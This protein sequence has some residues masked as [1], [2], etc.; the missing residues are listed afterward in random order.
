MTTKSL[1]GEKKV[2]SFNRICSGLFFEH[3]QY[4][5]K[6]PLCPP[7]PPPPLYI[8]GFDG[9]TATNLFGDHFSGKNFTYIQKDP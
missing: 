8:N 4:F 2:Y 3:I 9:V 7:T 5:G 6:G 1:A